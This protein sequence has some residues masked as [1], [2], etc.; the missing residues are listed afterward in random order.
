M[1]TYKEK[2]SKKYRKV[3]EKIN[4]F[5]NKE[6]LLNSPSE[7]EMVKENNINKKTEK[8]FYDQKNLDFI[9][10]SYFIK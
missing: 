1:E 5:K 9:K 10:N 2:G 6:L 4:Y 8:D 3:K 7:Q